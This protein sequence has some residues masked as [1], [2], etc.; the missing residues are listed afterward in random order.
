MTIP[1]QAR[2][3]HR[4]IPR[5][6]AAIVVDAKTGKVLYQHDADQ[7]RYPASISKVMTLYILFQELA[8]GHLTMNTM[9]PV[10]KHAAAAE[11]SKLG[12]RPGAKISVKDA[13]ESI[14]TISANDMARV[15][16]E[17]IGGTE[18]NFGVRMTKTARELG[19]DH[20]FYDNAS[21]LPDPRQVTTVRDQARL[22]IAIYEHFPQYA[23]FFHLH[24]FHYGN[25]TYGNHD[26][27]L[28]HKG[29]DGLKTG[30]TSAAGFNLLTASQLGDRHLVV[31]AFGFA[32]S[33]ARDNKVRSLV[34]T[35]LPK[36][37]NGSYL[38]AALIPEPNHGHLPEVTL[39]AVQPPP[40]P[41]PVP[42]FRES[43]DSPADTVTAYAPEPVLRPDVRLAS[44]NANAAVPV[45]PMD[46]GVKPA[47]EAANR[48]GEGTRAR[49]PEQRP[50]VIGQ[51]INKTLLGAPPSP[52]G[53]TRPSAP[54]V[55]PV[56][57]GANGQAIDLTTSGA[58]GNEKTA[59]ST[60]PG[61]SWTVQVGAAPSA[62]GARQLLS[63]ATGKV[64][65]LI[66][67][68][69]YVEKIERNGQTFY[70]A[71]FIGFGDRNQATQM[72]ATL[73]KENMSC[74]AM[75]S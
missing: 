58:I 40:R 18:A 12:L 39:A 1:S 71:R 13:I 52:L 75:Q 17:E 53:T 51:W 2:S 62:D 36:A 68:R 25:R 49:G 74:L 3:R 20:T 72:C 28:G 14:V 29:V 15:I 45:Q 33:R 56:G 31:A 24:S 37:R 8:A 5:A 10:S 4:H 60:A 32:T 27:L 22:A 57:V 47:V 70:R 42:A 34:D 9:M 44:I 21:G 30:F 63:N 54:L 69:T 59:D 16:A 19:M 73:K 48:L 67:L 35:Y 65:S 11:P 55:R 46:I 26:R 61:D 64:K 50:D 66:D 6:Y 38:R 23:H 43:A 41:A 7:L